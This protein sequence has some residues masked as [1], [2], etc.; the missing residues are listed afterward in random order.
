MIRSNAMESREIT[1]ANGHRR[2]AQIGNQMK[3]TDRVGSRL[4]GYGIIMNVTFFRSPQKS[5]LKQL[6]DTLTSPSWKTLQKVE[7]AIQLPALACT[8][9]VALKR[10]P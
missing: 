9:F 7:K 3:M 10:H 8:L 1:I 5:T 2:I 4:I 6:N